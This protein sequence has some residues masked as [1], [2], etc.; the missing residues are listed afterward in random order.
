MPEED[1]MDA[2]QNREHSAQWH[3]LIQECGS[4]EQAREVLLRERELLRSLMRAVR[5]CGLNPDLLLL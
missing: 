4:E 2:P 1:S 5:S 3:A